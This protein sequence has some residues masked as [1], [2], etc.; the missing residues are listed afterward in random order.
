M[1]QVLKLVIWEQVAICTGYP[2]VRRG[3]QPQQAASG[4]WSSEAPVNVLHNG[5][6][7]SGQTAQ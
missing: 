7:L 3:P 2:D 4:Q 6:Q 5:L 1:E